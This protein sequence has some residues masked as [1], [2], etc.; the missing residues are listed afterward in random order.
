MKLFN[1]HNTDGYTKTELDALNEELE[2]R[3]EKLGL[4]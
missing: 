4:E 2:A 1:E 3:A